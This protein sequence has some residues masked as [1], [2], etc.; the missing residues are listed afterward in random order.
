MLEAMR[1]GE[2]KVDPYTADNFT[3]VLRA[4]Q[5]VGAQWIDVLKVDIE[6]LM[7]TI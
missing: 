1:R 4:V 7:A 6:G 2:V 3:T 5:S